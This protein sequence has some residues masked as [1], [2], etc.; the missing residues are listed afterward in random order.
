[1]FSLSLRRSARLV[2]AA[3][4]CAGALCVTATAG[5][6]PA[7]ESGQVPHG[8]QQRHDSR[9]RAHPSFQV[10]HQPADLN[11]YL[12]MVIQDVDAYWTRIYAA[13]RLGEPHVSFL[14]TTPGQ[15]VPNGCVSGTDDDAAFYCPKDDTIYVSQVFAGKV[16]NEHGDFGAAVVIAHEYAH[17]VQRELGVYRFKT[18]TS[19][20]FELE[21][22]CMA[23]MWANWEG[24]RRTLDDG[25]VL[26]A[27]G[28][29]HALGDYELSAPD[30]HGTPRQRE[31]AFMRGYR[32]GE[33]ARCQ[34]LLAAG[35]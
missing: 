32:G 23:G 26:E 4:A 35:G 8:A 28:T 2:A 30:H 15:S 3:C 6:A 16:W 27:A 11:D 10:P 34:R 14:W 24:R 7:E 22:D 13:G 20:P 29:F 31:R 33:S 5:A 18:A 12:S 1:M 9:P 21:A 17:N 25:D 19:M